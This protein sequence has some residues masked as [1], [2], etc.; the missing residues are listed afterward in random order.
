M[1][2]TKK[3]VK[4]AAK[5]DVK[6]AAPVEEVKT[7]EVKE[8]APAKRAAAKKTS[9]K[10]ETAAKETAAKKAPEKKTVAKKAAPEKEEAAVKE[11]TAAKKPAARRTA[12]KAAE[13]AA[14]VFFQYAGKEIV[15]KEILEEAV[16]AYKSTHAD[17]EVKDIQLYIVADEGAA[18]YVVNGEASDDFKIML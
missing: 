7:E 5:A 18:Y 3:E 1:A 2:E 6:P 16:R 9:A 10:K 4:T 13:P 11:E 8:A 15:A 14:S 12:K 17:A